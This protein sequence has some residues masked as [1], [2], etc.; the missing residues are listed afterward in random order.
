MQQNQR[1]G[2][3]RERLI[4][5]DDS[6]ALTSF[7]QRLYPK[8]ILTFSGKRK[9]QRSLAFEIERENI[10]ELESQVETMPKLRH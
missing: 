7:W 4:H 3:L 5:T 10:Q 8:Q 6:L 1:S 9:S 2:K